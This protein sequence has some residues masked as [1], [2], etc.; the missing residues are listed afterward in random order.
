MAVRE[1]SPHGPPRLRDHIARLYPGA[2]IVMIEPLG[3]DAGATK[4]ATAKAAGYGMPVRVVI[5][6]DGVQRELVWRVASANEFG[7]D[8]RADRAAAM[9]QAFDDF[10][11]IPQHVRAVDLGVIRGSGELLSTRDATEHYLI[12][13]YAPGTIYAHDLRRIAAERIVRTHDV[14]RVNT[15][16]RYL[17]AL[18]TPIPHPGARY[19][20]AIR[21]LVGSGEGIFGIIDGYPPDVPGAPPERLQAIEARCAEWRWRLRGR[22]ARLCRTH[23]DFHPFNIVFDGDTPTLL[24]ASRGGCGDPADDVTA[25]AINF[26]LFALDAPASWRHGLGVLWRH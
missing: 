18:H 20:R 19:R 1:S 2:T 15:L 21:D 25:L 12:T 6:E 7:H 14:D 26:V 24:D 22:D 16:A 5:A 13:T 9:V 17:A 11:R 23:G 4:G 10:A 8:R 3:P